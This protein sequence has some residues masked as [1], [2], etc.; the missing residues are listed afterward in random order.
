MPFKKNAKKFCLFLNAYLQLNFFKMKDKNTAAI[1]A[2]VVGFVGIHQ[3]YLG[4]VV[5]G[6]GFIFLMKWKFKLAFFIAIAQGIRYLTMSQEDFEQK[7]V[8]D[9]YKR[10]DKWKEKW[11]NKS[12]DTVNQPVAPVETTVPSSSKSTWETWSAQSDNKTLKTE[13]I[14][15]YK[16]YDFRGAIADFEKVIVTEA[17]DNTT[18]FNLACCYATLEEK[19]KAFE[20]LSRAVQAGLK[21][22]EKI[23]KHDG[24]AYLRVQPEWDDFVAHKYK[25]VEPVLVR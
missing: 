25:I 17:N 14:K 16:E 15:K 8:K 12:K 6:L 4:N 2:F 1:L 10:K 13:G 7:Y 22:E 20:Y 24:L 9:F 5:L 21:D 3:F 11:G 23:A 18:L 19:D